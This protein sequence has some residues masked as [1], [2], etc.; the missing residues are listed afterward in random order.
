MP[1]H[2]ASLQAP[3]KGRPRQVRDRRLQGMDAVVQR[4]VTPTI[5][6][7]SD[8]VRTVVR[9]SFGPVHRSSTVAGF[10]HFATVL[11]FVGET[12]HWIVFQPSLRPNAPL[13]C[14]REA[15]R[16]SGHR[17]AM[18]RRQGITVLQP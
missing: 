14:A 10:R 2:G 18:L 4:L 7:S 17:C 13:G 6:A 15:W 16:L 9:G 11:E 5:V 3:M 12:I 1:R 8:A